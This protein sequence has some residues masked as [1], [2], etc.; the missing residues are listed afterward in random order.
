[1]I[2]ALWTAASGMGSQQLA[3]DT[4]AHNLSNVNTA[5]FRRSRVEMQDLK[6]TQV[7]PAGSGPMPSQ[8]LVGHGVKPAST[9]RSLR[10]GSLQP[11]GGELDL[12]IEGQGFFQ[13]RLPS[14]ALAYTRDGS[15][16]LNKDG[17]LVTGSGYRLVV[18]GNG[19]IP[20]G[21]T[22]V[23]ISPDGRITALAPGTSTPVEVG[24]VILADFPNPGGLESLGDN[25]FGVT[26]ATGE[27]TTGAP[28]TGGS[29]RLIQGYLEM[30]NVEV[31]QEM[32]DLIMAQRAYELNSRALKSADEMLGMANQLR[33]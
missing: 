24:Q 28:G 29:G 23:S 17:E 1:M 15:F 31:V 19:K 26:E 30:S 2:R 13:V 3:V 8:L 32:V 10:M 16:K 27:V 6:Y 4:I 33:R 21:A 14:G 18:S 22:E 25:L 20:A 5:G 12:A 7:I 9:Q 11:T